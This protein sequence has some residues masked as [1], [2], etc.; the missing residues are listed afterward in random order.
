[1]K[2]MFQ[3]ALCATL[4]LGLLPSAAHG[5]PAVRSGLAPA[6]FATIPLAVNHARFEA[7]W[8]RVLH[9]GIGANAISERASHLSGTQRLQSVNTSANLAIAF[10]DDRSNGKASDYWSNAG[11]TLARGS[12]DCEDYAIAKMHLLIR[13]GVPAADMFMVVGDDFTLRQAHAM[14]LVRQG[15]K[16]WVL[17]NLTD[18][19]RMSNSYPDFRPIFSFGA[20]GMW[21]HGYAVGT[22]PPKVYTRPIAIVALAPNKGRAPVAKQHQR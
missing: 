3:R 10:R 5:L 15:G 7:R 14:L 11:Q 20:T 16:F 13:A 12:G 2:R 6:A 19:I 8:N 22:A 4:V 18:Q 9:R 17:D 1:M 21:V